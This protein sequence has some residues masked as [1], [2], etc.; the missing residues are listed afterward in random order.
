MAESNMTR[1]SFVQSAAFAGA[2]VAGLTMAGS[3]T[4]CSPKQEKKP[5]ENV[6]HTQQFA[7]V[8]YDKVM[9][10]CCH[11][12]I[13]HCPVLAYVKDGVVV[14]LAGDPDAPESKGS[15]CVKG[16]NQLQTMYSPRRI[17]HPIRRAGERGENKWEIISWD[18]AVDDAATHIV[19]TINKYGPYAV[20][21]STGGGGA[22]S[23]NQIKT[24]CVSLGTP[25]V[26]E[27]GAAQCLM[28]RIC[29]TVF[30]YGNN[31]RLL[32]DGCNYRSLLFT[33]PLFRGLFHF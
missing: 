2:A 7:K 6:E 18:E 32:F 31:Q 17:L 9:K 12:C 1:R 27:P 4:A 14:K 33:N 10:T 30:M 16:L 11:G 25:N 24:S 19:D 3:L 23:S 20:F 21:G 22:Y 8:E 5:K 28:P 15:I 26:F 29:A 13:A